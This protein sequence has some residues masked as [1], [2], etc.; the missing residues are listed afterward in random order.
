[1]KTVTDLIYPGTPAPLLHGGKRVS[2][3]EMLPV[4]D[5]SGN[6][7]AQASRACCHGGEKPLH[8]VVHLHIINRRGEIYL[9]QR[10]AGKD[11]LPL[12]WDTAVG[13]HVSYGEFI[14]E[15]LYRE[16]AEELGLHDFLPQRLCTYV[17][18]S[19]TERELVNVFAAVG[20]YALRP[21]PEEL[22]GGRFWTTEEIEAAVGKGILTPNFE[23]EYA[24]V[25]D[26][27]LALL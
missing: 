25:K 17:F 4:V 3:A 27:L 12:R 24:R 23:Q 22:A 8:P 5:E 13:G 20:E 15:A 14:S 16:A 10:G 2:A 26:A 1:M 7:R 11:L 18:E 6:V 9:Q 21:D 19:E